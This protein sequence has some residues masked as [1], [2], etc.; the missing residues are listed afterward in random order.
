MMFGGVAAAHAAAPSAEEFA[1]RPHVE[2]VSISTDGRYVALIRTLDDGR[3]DVVVTDLAGGPRQRSGRSSH[4]DR[5]PT[6]S[7]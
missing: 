7:K 1:L 2:D 6:T 5:S 3:A 4:D